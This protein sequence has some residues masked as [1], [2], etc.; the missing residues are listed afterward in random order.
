MKV[1]LKVSIVLSL[2]A[3][4]I[5][6]ISFYVVPSVTVK[7]ISN[8]SIQAAKVALPDA[9]LDFGPIE[10]KEQNTILFFRVN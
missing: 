10:A 5:Y 2:I 3:V 6:C 8:T 7:N 4:A 1:V 9:G